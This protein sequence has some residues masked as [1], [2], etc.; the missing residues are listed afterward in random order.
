MTDVTRTSTDG[1]PNPAA[2]SRRR[3]TLLIAGVVWLALGIVL[4]VVIGG[5]TGFIPDDPVVPRIGFIDAGDGRTAIVVGA[6]SFAQTEGIEIRSGS[7]ARDGRILW[8]VT[9]SGDSATDAD[10]GRIVIGEV[11]D[12]FDEVEPFEADL[13]TLWHAEVDNRC[14]FASN[15]APRAL[16]TDLVTLESGERVTP[17]GFQDGDTGFSSCDTN[18]LGGRLAAF[19]GLISIAIGGVLVLVVW[20]DRRRGL[21]PELT[22]RPPTARS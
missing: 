13:P 2:G 12:G 19:A 21:P 16:A 15:T 4:L 8:H 22:A 7:D 17:A 11:P 14:Y 18:S 5:A 9:R 1:A 6:T 20:W 10:A 3:R